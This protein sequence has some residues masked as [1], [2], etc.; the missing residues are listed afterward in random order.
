M[1]VLGRV[2]DDILRPITEF[3][4][5]L[6]TAPDSLPHELSPHIGGLPVK[7]LSEGYDGSCMDVPWVGKRSVVE[8]PGRPDFGRF[9]ARRGRVPELD[10]VDGWQ[11]TGAVL[12]SGI[13]R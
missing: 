8:D 3:L 2:N 1:R 5:F 6:D 11:D 13:D 12:R 7:A 10:R 4:G 9:G